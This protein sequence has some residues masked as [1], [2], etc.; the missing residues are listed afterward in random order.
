MLAAP[1]T[2][3]HPAA[4]AWGERDPPS[5][6]AAVPA[7]GVARAMSLH[8]DRMSEARQGSRHARRPADPGPARTGGGRALALRASGVLGQ[9]EP[10]LAGEKV[11]H[12]HQP[13]RVVGVGQAQLAQELTQARPGPEAAERSPFERPAVVWLIVA[14]S[15]AGI[16]GLTLRLAGAVERFF[17]IRPL[18]HGESETRLHA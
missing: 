2:L 16:A 17:T 12:L 14:A 18:K 4:K 6:V 7:P 5:R 1:L 9:I 15:V 10:A 11:A 8:T 13:H 3:Y